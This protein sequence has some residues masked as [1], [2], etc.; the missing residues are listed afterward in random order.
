MTQPAWLA[1]I[2]AGRT[3]RIFDVIASGVDS[4]FVDPGGVSLVQ[5]CAY[6]G[7]VSALRYLLVHGATLASLGPDL[8]L[9]SAAFHG[10]WQLCQ[11]LLEQGAS[12]QAIDPVT[13]ET[14]LHAALCSDDRQRYD[15]VVKLLL[16][17]GID[18]N[19]KTV[20][21]QATAGFMRDCRTKAET[22]LHRA[23]ACGNANT[24]Q[25]LLTAGAQRDCVDCH[26]DS[27]LSWASW[28]RRP[29]EILRL[30]C[31]GSFQIHPDY[32]PLRSNLIGTP[33]FHR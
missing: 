25:L 21:N 29:A 18:V 11:F 19:A 30:L 2:A 22:A 8:G 4:H 1:E 28:Q 6:Y 31:Y 26:G 3:D 24:I 15:E 10:H 7:D 17:A 9:R 20:A 32:Q 14:A 16:A 33:L 5:H 27:P 13:G 12:V 23:A